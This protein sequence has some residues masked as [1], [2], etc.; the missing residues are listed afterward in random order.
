MNTEMELKSSTYYQS[1][2]GIKYIP[3]VMHNEIHPLF[4]K[5]D[6]VSVK[7][8]WFKQPE[9]KY[10]EE[11]LYDDSWIDREYHK[12]S[13]YVNAKAYARKIYI[14]Y[15][16]ET[17]EFYSDAKVIV[18]FK[19]DSTTFKFKTDAEAMVFIND[20]KTKCEKCGNKLL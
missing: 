19:E 16:E 9:V 14:S 18:S 10:A 11:D 13:L 8:H 6:I 3:K 4:K 2:T 7:K 17:K 1:I 20:L 15:D 5:G 12:H